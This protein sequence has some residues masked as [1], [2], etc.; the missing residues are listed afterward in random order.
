MLYTAYLSITWKEQPLSGSVCLP[1]HD[2]EPGKMSC[3]PIIGFEH[4]EPP[5]MEKEPKPKKAPQPT[6][7]FYSYYDPFA[8]PPKPDHFKDYEKRGVWVFDDRPNFNSWDY[9]RKH[10]D[11]TV[12][13]PLEKIAIELYN[14][15]CKDDLKHALLKTVELYFYR[16]DEESHKEKEYFRITLEHAII[17]QVK[18]WFD[19]VKDGSCEN[20]GPMIQLQFRYQRITWLHIDGYLIHTDEWE[21]GFGEYLKRDFKAPMEYGGPE[22]LAPL[23]INESKDSDIAMA[24]FSRYKEKIED[25]N[26][27]GSSMHLD[28]NGRA[29]GYFDTL[30]A[31]KDWKNDPDQTPDEPVYYGVR[32]E[33]RHVKGFVWSEWVAWPKKIKMPG[34]TDC[35]V[36][37]NPPKAAPLPE[38]WVQNWLAEKLKPGWGGGLDRWY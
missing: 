37:T 16:Y 34:F 19:N 6:R 28:D 12:V 3:V 26:F 29:R 18:Q 23:T 36:H 15:I 5:V 33:N 32:V 20:R 14:I 13:I 35:H 4:G 7:Y 27:S 31:N 17:T 2:D 22:P 10:E 38:L 9:T 25:M 24:L 1:D 30:P 8:R 21:N 11:I